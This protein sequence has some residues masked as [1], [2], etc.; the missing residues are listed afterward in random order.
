MMGVRT[1]VISPQGVTILVTKIVKILVHE[2][3]F[4]SIELS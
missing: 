1:V 3:T 4:T 2:D